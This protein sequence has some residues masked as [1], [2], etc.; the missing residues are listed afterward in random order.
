MHTQQ[1]LVIAKKEDREQQNRVLPLAI[2]GPD[3]MGKHVKRRMPYG[4]PPDPLIAESMHAYDQHLLL[5]VF[6]QEPCVT[7]PRKDRS[8]QHTRGT[9]TFY[10]LCI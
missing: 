3:P 2:S 8:L 6:M 7:T 9:G 1:R 4:R 5:L 10:S